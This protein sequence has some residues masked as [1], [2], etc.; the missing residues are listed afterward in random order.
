MRYVWPG[1]VS[2]PT[3]LTWI[4]ILV[5]LSGSNPGWGPA[6]V[7][8]SFVALCACIA[9]AMVKPKAREWRVAAA[10]NAVPFVLIVLLAALMV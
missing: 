10:L 8:M 5:R 3:L 9:M 7:G 2:I 1:V 4:F 6:V